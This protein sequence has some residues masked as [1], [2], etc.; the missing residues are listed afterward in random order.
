[1]P[2]SQNRNKCL[3][4]HW[5]NPWRRIEGDQTAD[6][7]RVRLEEKLMARGVPA[8]LYLPVTSGTPGVVACTCEKDTTQNH[9]RAC[10]ECYGRGLVPGFERFLHETIH[11]GSS[12]SASY[13]LVGCTRDLRIKPHRIL[14]DTGIT[15]ATI[16]TQDKAYSNADSDS[17]STQTDAFLRDTGN[18]VTTEFSTDAGGSWFNVSLINGANQPVGAGNIRFRVT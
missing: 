13:T 14:M 10:N 11:F 8:W 4:G 1:M 6:K 15:S 9:D 18:T 12:E 16:E 17:W 5:G 7:V 3:H 2:K